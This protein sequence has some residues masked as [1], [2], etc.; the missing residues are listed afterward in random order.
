MRE[1][2]LTIYLTVNSFG[3]EKWPDIRIYIDSWEI[4]NGLILLVRDPDI[5]RWDYLIP[6]NQ[7]KR[8]VV[9]PIGVGTK[10]ADFCVSES[11]QNKGSS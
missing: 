9:K 6:R 11:I 4:E 1:N 8:H 7:R 2:P 3:E 10:F 5:W